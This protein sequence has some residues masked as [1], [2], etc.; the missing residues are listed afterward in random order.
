MLKSDDGTIVG[1]ALWIL[2]NIAADSEATEAII[3]S[4][5]IDKILNMLADMKNLTPEI[6]ENTTWVL[7]CIC[8]QHPSPPFS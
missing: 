6:V 7:A 3:G 2:R 5:T 4:G 8:N 1:Q